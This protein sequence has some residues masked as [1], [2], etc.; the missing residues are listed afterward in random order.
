MEAVGIDQSVRFIGMGDYIEIWSGE[1]SSEPF[2]GPDDFRRELTALMSD[3]P[4][5][6]AN[7]KEVKD[8]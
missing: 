4:S 1:S 7:G 5:L 8:E 6:P 2:V 3:E